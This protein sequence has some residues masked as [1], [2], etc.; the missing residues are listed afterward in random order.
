M[1]ADISGS[2]A[3]GARQSLRH[4]VLPVEHEP[5][6]RSRHID[7]GVWRRKLLR[8]TGLGGGRAVRHDGTGQLPAG[9]QSGLTTVNATVPWWQS[10]RTLGLY[11]LAHHRGHLTPAIDTALVVVAAANACQQPFSAYRSPSIGVVI[12]QSIV[13]FRLGQQRRRR[14]SGDGVARSRTADRRRELP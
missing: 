13:R 12:G 5:C 14:E 1:P 10:V 4:C 2:V 9:R 11:S 6:I 8:R 3:M 7:R